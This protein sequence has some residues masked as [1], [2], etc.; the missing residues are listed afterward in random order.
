MRHLEPISRLKTTHGTIVSL[1]DEGKINMIKDKPYS[2]THYL[3]IDEKNEFNKIYF[4]LLEIENRVDKISHFVSTIYKLKRE[5]K[6]EESKSC[7][8][9]RYLLSNSIRS[10]V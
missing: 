10:I 2:Q 1:I 9:V 8:C 3:T 7:S 4:Q 6:P 5:N